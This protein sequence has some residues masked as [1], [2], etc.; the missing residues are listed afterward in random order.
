MVY[1][2]FMTRIVLDRLAK[3]YPTQPEPVLRGL[4]LDVPSGELVA[5]LGPS[6]SGKSTILKLI[7]GIEPPDSGDVRFDDRSLATIPANR[8][9][10]VLMFQRAYLF[11]FLNVADNIAFGLKLRHRDRA[12]V[13]RE[14]AR[15][16]DLVELPGIEHKMP[17]QLS[18]GQQQRVAL[19][20][21]LIVEPRVLLLDEPLSSLDTAI[22]GAMQEAIRRIQRELGITTLLVTHDLGEAVAM[23][24]RTA[25]LLHGEIEAY[26][27]PQ[28]LFERPPTQAAARFVGVSTFVRGR[29]S[30]DTLA[31]IHGPLRVVA[32][33][34]PRETIFAIRPEHLRIV[35]GDAPNALPGTLRD[36]I[37]KG[38]FT[39][40]HIA[41]GD[42][43]LRV[44]SYQPATIQRGDHV[45]V[46]FP[47]E[48]LFEVT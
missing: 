36:A 18:G 24:D 13:R 3:A 12:T 43:L 25:L 11:P 27:R 10:A 2:S 47:P 1:G 19:A 31:T 26:D 20:R 46:Q 5:L 14:V 40:Y 23:S 39:E 22:R 44:R 33:G 37:Y 30:G 45:R 6:G 7:A 17:G 9:G 16:L 28:R 35:A 38:E 15:M 41:V 42:D 21:A 32:G 4:S 34:A 29:L 48:Y 8:R